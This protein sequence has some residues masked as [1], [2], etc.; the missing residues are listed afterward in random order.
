[1]PPRNTGVIVGALLVAGGGIGYYLT[2][3]KVSEG[4]LAIFSLSLSD[5][6]ITVVQG[7]TARILVSVAKISGNK[8]VTLSLVTSSGIS[9]TFAPS[10]GTPSFGS[11]LTLS[12]PQTA[13]VGIYSLVVHGDNVGETADVSLVVNVV[14]GQPPQPGYGSLAV[15]V[16]Y[17][18]YQDPVSTQVLVT[19]GGLTGTSPVVFP[20]IIEG[21]YTVSAT[22][23]G[24]TRAKGE[25]VFSGRTTTSK[26]L[27]QGGPV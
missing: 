27:I 15:E 13:S 7:S 10:S 19:P 21:S 12:V 9:A 22:F 6:P 26:V 18:T 14:S 3:R 23:S 5:S 11:W 2:H 4:G 25:S 17:G 16:Y 20:N 24:I 8:P 1:M